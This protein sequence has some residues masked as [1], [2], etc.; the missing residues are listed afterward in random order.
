[1]DVSPQA[2]RQIEDLRQYFRDHQRPEAIRGLA[3]ALIEADR[4]IQRNPSAGLAASRPYPSVARPGRAWIKAGRYWIAYR[5]TPP[6]AIVAVF[7]ETA[8]IT[9]RFDRS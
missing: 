4:K 6:L 5:T 8:D 9:G 2:E 7:F 3:A 1:M